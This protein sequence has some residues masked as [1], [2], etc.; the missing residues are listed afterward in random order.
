VGE[1]EYQ[2]EYGLEEYCLDK[3]RSTRSAEK[4]RFQDIKPVMLIG[5][6][7]V[8]SIQLYIVRVCCGN[9][10]NDAPYKRH[11]GEYRPLLFEMNIC[12]RRKICIEQN[13]I[14]EGL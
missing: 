3:R 13:Q 14:L 7:M 10:D 5:L 8:V 12:I 2:W 6:C 4:M 1:P 9:K 11:D